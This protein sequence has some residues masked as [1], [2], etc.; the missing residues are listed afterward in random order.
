MPPPARS[1]H[2]P[3]ARR[4]GVVG[5]DPVVVV[6]WWGASDYAKG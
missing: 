4:V 5:D 6:D 3:P 2:C 1:P